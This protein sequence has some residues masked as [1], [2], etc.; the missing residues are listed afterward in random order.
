MRIVNGSV[1]RVLTNLN[2]RKAPATTAPRLATIQADV[3]VTALAAPA[4]G[5]LRCVVRG[6]TH[7]DHPDTIFSEQSAKSS[8]QARSGGG[9]GWQY[10]ERIGYAS[11]A[12]PAW[13]KIEDGPA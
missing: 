9:L 11:M 5:W 2:L 1:L 7:A 6:W 4:N 3:L 12:N 13:W 8:I 10:V